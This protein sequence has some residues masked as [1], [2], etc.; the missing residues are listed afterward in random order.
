MKT[1][2]KCGAENR[3]TA[4]ECRLCATPLEGPGD[5]LEVRQDTGFQ[6]TMPPDRIIS[7]AEP[8]GQHAPASSYA[9]HT[10]CPQCQA[11]N[12]PDWAFCQQ[13]G[14]QLPARKSRSDG[15]EAEV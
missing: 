13:C 5:L 12:E 14:S 1:C 10:L 4:S 15:T 2:P 9:G 6:G 11:V 8:A 7:G 3:Q